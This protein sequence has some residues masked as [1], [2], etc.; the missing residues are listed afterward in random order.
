MAISVAVTN[1]GT[2]AAETPV[3]AFVT[4]PDSPVERWP[5]KLAAFARVSLQPG[6][7]R[8]VHMA[9]LLDDLRWR[10]QGRWHFQSGDHTITVTTGAGDPLATRQ[11]WLE[12]D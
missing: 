1:A 4:P 5:R 6:E 10:G 7:T 2:A 12:H 3:L 11:I 9:V 8:I